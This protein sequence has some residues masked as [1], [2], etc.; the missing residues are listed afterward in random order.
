MKTYAEALQGKLKQGIAELPRAQLGK[1]SSELKLSR[2]VLQI[3]PVL[4]NTIHGV[5]EDAASG[6]EATVNEING[7]ILRQIVW[8]AWVCC[9]VQK[10]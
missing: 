5:L 8:A 6:T 2:E 3:V 10:R 7:N 4:E 9:C 1:R